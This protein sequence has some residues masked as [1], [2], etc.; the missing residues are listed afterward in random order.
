MRAKMKAFFLFAIVISGVIIVFTY[1]D[2]LE[3]NKLRLWVESA[4]V[5]APFMF[6][7]VYIVSVV[8]FL[9][10][11]I[12][13]IAGGVLFGPIWGAFY[14]L[15]AATT[16][17]VLAFLIS[18]YLASQWVQQRLGGRL[19]QI[20]DGVESEGWRFVAFVRLV[21]LFPFNVVNYAFGLTRI[22]LL[23]Y[24]LAT[25]ICM[26]PGAVAYTYLGYAGAAAGAHDEK[27][28]KKALFALALVAAAAFLPRLIKRLRK[29]DMLSVEQLKERL[30]NGDDVLVIDVRKGE[31]YTGEL[32]HIENSINIPIEQLQQRLDELRRNFQHKPIALVCR[33][34][35]LSAKAAQLLVT[36]GFSDAKVVKGGMTDWNSKGYPIE[37]NT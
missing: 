9:P 8:L 29:N 5:F 32:G 13:T 26:T 10:A 33:T 28:I 14:N 27:L 3:V 25:Y 12:L 7:G 19:K 34:Q 11:L 2:Q 17:A 37:K 15:T 21:P 6:M 4:G 31:D 24:V 22:N 1:G 35:R 20:V 23:H 30:D 18:R 36:E 16:G